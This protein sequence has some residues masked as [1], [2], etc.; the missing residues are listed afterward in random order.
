MNRD[1][2]EHKSRVADRTER[3]RERLDK[4][5][6][7]AARIAGSQVVVAVDSS[8]AGLT[9]HQVSVA[10]TQQSPSIVTWNQLADFGELWLTFRLVDNET[11]EYV[12]ERFEA[13]LSDPAQYT[14]IDSAPP[15]LGD[16]M[17]DQLRSWPDFNSSR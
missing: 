12:C 16:N 11:A 7:L 13:V 4:I 8:E 10:L 6:G 3:V 2:A 5:P 15:N 14:S 17:L 1:E 9:A